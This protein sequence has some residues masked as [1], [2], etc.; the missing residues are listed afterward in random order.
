MVTNII[1]VDKK[2]QDGAK[3]DPC[4]APHLVQAMLDWELPILAVFEN[5]MLE[6]GE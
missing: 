3:I 5:L 4:E 2:W 6:K 1:H